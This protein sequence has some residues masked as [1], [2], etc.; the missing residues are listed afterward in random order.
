[1][2][3]LGYR[4]QVRPEWVVPLVEN[5]GRY[6]NVM[7]VHANEKFMRD[8]YI[9]SFNAFCGRVGVKQL[10][11]QLPSKAIIDEKQCARVCDFMS[12]M[13]DKSTA[14]MNTYFWGHTDVNEDYLHVIARTVREKGLTFAIEN[15]PVK[16]NLIGYLKALKQCAIKYNFRV[17][18]DIGTLFYS[19]MLD[20]VSDARLIAMF[21]N[22]PWWKGNVVLVHFHDYNTKGCFLNFGDGY[23]AKDFKPVKSILQ[24][25]DENVPVIFKTQV[26]DFG[27]QGVY[28]TKQFLDLWNE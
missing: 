11:F 14:V 27:T 4:I 13:D 20:N 23:F 9:K 26:Q 1:M 3:S 28:E 12:E 24:C 7:E 8:V 18:L 10:A 16:R 6:F 15:V 2:L 25:L 17:S 21:Q 19:A 22:D 5:Y